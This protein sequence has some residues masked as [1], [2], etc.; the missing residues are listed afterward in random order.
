[1][2]QPDDDKTQAV[3]VLSKGTVINHYRIVEKIGA[4]G[5]GDVYLAEDTELNRQVALKFLSSH[6]CQDTDCRTRFKR[7]AQAA[8]KLNH[9]N[10][11][12]IYEVSEFNGR[13]FFAME[14]VQ[15]QSLRELIKV[16]E[17]PIERVIDLAIQICEALHK[18]H[19]AGITHRD[20]KP[21]NI[22]I[23]SDG[24]PKLC[25]FGLAAV[26][27]SDHLTKAGST[28][29]TVSYMSPEQLR[30][31]EIDHRTD[32]F[33]LGVVLYEL[34]T[35]RSPFAAE[36][37]AAVQHHILSGVPEPMAR[38][39]AVIPEGLQEVIDRALEKDAQVRYQSAADLMAD[40]RRLRRRSSDHFETMPTAPSTT[41]ATWF[42]IR[43][44]IA[45][46]IVIML[47]VMFGVIFQSRAPTPPTAQKHL[48]VIPFVNLGGVL[49]G[50]SFCDGLME[51]LT[52]KLTQFT[53][54]EGSLWVVPASEVRDKKVE[55]AGQARRVFGVTLAVTGSVQQYRDGLRITF[56]LVDAAT[57]RQLRSTVVDE[58][59]TDVSELQDSIVA[60]LAQMLDIQLRPDSRRVL[61]AGGTSSSGAYYSYLQGRGYLQRYESAGSLDSA[62]ILF[63]TAI[64][65]DSNYALAYAGLG[66]V[67]WEKY[68]LSM[69]LKWVA[70]AISNSSR[71]LKLN[72]RLAP[73]LVTLGIIHRGTGQYEEAVRYLQNALQIDSMD[74]EAYI[75][76]AS[77][78]GSLGRL[79]DAESTYQRA[80][81]L[82]P[83]YWRNHYYLALFYFDRGR[84]GDAMR[85]A[86]TA[87]SLAPVAAYPCAFLGGLY[88]NLGLTDRAKTLLQRSIDLE[89]SYAAYSNLGAI[90]QWEK[91]IEKAVDMY[92]RALKLDDRD[93]RVWINLASMY[94]KLPKRLEKAAATYDSAIALAERNREINP[95]DPLL[96]CYLAESYAAIGEHN[97][98][99]ALAQQATQLAPENSEIMVRTAIV[100][101]TAGQREDALMSIGKAVEKGFSTEQIRSLDELH[102]LVVDP[103]FDSI[104]SVGASSESKRKK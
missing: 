79:D 87:E 61:G 56:N 91:Q 101:E 27:G 66:E 3:T 11:V 104:V 39:R 77:A 45:A 36:N 78:Y 8:A 6:L 82:R 26:E 70:P 62:A 33:S 93:Y 90:Y 30:G 95:H 41:R 55:S 58:K 80:V 54:I 102:D 81:K 73:V 53:E 99:L 103:R 83:D 100:Y 43:Y 51:T 94:H 21:A 71:A 5:M 57:E 14:H 74:N 20:I 92:E 16:N 48:A 63:G 22:L 86:A 15:G 24:R 40:L 52:S 28:L 13:P 65:Q 89:P 31:E 97:K 10:I 25:D 37:L 19:Q 69:D 44:A 68:K 34:V 67:Y 84:S 46:A 59:L 1:M 88:V 98:S 42:R 75:E 50:Q 12:T 49:T 64:R 29:G 2:S 47:S 4:G 9:P 23:D 85:Q 38:Y 32:I 76:L 7:E 35:G 72:D 17:L 18:A 60:E 96:L